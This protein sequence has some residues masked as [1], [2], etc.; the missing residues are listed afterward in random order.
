MIR[1][2]LININEKRIKFNVYNMLIYLLKNNTRIDFLLNNKGISKFLKLQI[3][4]LHLC[5]FSLLMNNVSG[6]LGAHIVFFI[7]QIE[8]TTY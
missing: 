4:L 2:K 8:L 1:L 5:F 7:Q 6:K 3:F